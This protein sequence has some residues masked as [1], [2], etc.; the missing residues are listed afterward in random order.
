MENTAA[1]SR[2]T[3]PDLAKPFSAPGACRGVQIRQLAHYKRC[4]VRC[5]IGEHPLG[6][7]QDSTHGTTER[8]MPNALT[9][10]TRKPALSLTVSSL[11]TQVESP[12][13]KLASCRTWVRYALLVRDWS[14]YWSQSCTTR[15]TWLE[16]RDSSFDEPERNGKAGATKLVPRPGL[17]GL[18]YDQ[19]SGPSTR[20]QGC[21]P[22]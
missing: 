1:R 5:N 7:G 14:L 16:S 9:C 12:T 4:G 10:Q 19:L 8:R 22:D 11:C 3:N 13:R 15:R 6:R 18:D 17:R 21:H 2:I 20:C